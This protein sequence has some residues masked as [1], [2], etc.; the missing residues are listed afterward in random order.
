TRAAALAEIGMGHARRFDRTAGS[1]RRA[2][3]ANRSSAPVLF[4]LSFHGRRIRVLHFEPVGR[5]AGTIGGILA[6]RGNAFEA[7]LAGMGEDGR[8]VTLDMLVE[9]DAGAGVGTEPKL[10]RY[11]MGPV[12]FTGWPVGLLELDP[13]LPDGAHFVPGQ[14]ALQFN[15]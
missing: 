15:V 13:F 10:E 5:A 2:S 11:V 12:L 4:C 7:E 14:Q 9:P 6:L 1:L 3:A 8:A